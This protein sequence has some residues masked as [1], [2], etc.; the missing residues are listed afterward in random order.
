[1]VRRHDLRRADGDDEVFRFPTAQQYVNQVEA[2]AASVLDGRP[3]PC[4]S[5]SRVGTQ[6]VI[7]AVFDRLGQPG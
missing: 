5:N 1:M 6:R 4:R 7:D 2:V 3:I